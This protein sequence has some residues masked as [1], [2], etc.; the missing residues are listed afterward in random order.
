MSGNP[1][2]EARLED[3]GEGSACQVGYASH[4]GDLEGHE[5]K[6]VATDGE[7]EPAPDCSFELFESDSWAFS[8]LG[9]AFNEVCSPG[10]T[11][12]SWPGRWSGSVGAGGRGGAQSAGGDGK[13]ALREPCS[14]AQG[15]PDGPP[16]D[17]EPPGES[18]QEDAVEER[19]EAGGCGLAAPVGPLDP[20]LGQADRPGGGHAH[21][22]G[23][24]RHQARAGLGRRL[25]W[26]RIRRRR[27]RNFEEELG[28]SSG[29]AAGPARQPGGD[30]P[31][32]GALDVG[33]PAVY[34]PQPG[35]AAAD[36]VREGVAGK[37]FK[38]DQ[39][40][41]L[42]ADGLGSG[43]HPGCPDTGER[44]GGSNPSLL[45][46]GAGRP[47]GP[48][49]RPVGASCRGEPG[50]AA[51]VPFVCGSQPSGFQ[52]PAPESAL[53]ATVGRDLP[54][55]SPGHG[56]LHGEAQEAAEGQGPDRRRR[57]GAHAEGQAEGEG[58]GRRLEPK[59]H[60]FAGGPPCGGEARG[61]LKVPGATAPQIRV[62][63]LSNSLPRLLLSVRCSFA[64]FFADLSRQ[65]R[66][67]S[68]ATSRF[69]DG[70]TLL[71]LL[72]CCDTS[73]AELSV[74]SGP[75][76]ALWS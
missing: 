73:G 12:L 72:K 34:D 8:R 15:D 60:A 23:Q 62:G 33:G 64:S 48:G 70:A 54:P 63:A 45:D 20:V 14:E 55:P 3:P 59:V 22:E 41:G 38:A 5:G 75:P 26:R 32:R 68:G 24:Q 37:P 31:C 17:R 11:R 16:G 10:R 19:A 74:P 76:V 40:S 4:D 67:P 42:G 52:R 18:D 21:V 25:F 57:R 9:P 35:N 39:L 69:W 7:G 66:Q 13:P 29:F 58:Q 51:A 50:A 30:L 49:S 71:L 6:P 46:A 43:R 47:G 36:F 27:G 65:P 44:E 56:E 2:A 28:G 53:G 61:S 1:G